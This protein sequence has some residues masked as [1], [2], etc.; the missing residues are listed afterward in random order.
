M[1]KFSTQKQERKIFFA[2]VIIVIVA[3]T[4]IM[5]FAGLSSDTAKEKGENWSQRADLYG[6]TFA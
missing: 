1:R 2:E 6:K 4:C 3:A 5:L